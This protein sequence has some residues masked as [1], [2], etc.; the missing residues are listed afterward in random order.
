MLQRLSQLQARGFG[1]VHVKE[2]H[3]AR[4]FLQLL[5]S[6]AHTGSFGDNLRLPQ[7]VKQELQL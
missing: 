3:V 1:H 2:H 6:L 5:D 7:L 4:I